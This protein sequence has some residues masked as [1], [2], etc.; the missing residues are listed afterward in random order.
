MTDLVDTAS[1]TRTVCYADGRD[2]DAS[3][4]FYTEV[5]GMDVAMEDPVLG[6]T[7]AA[8]RSAQVLI[9]PAG[10]EEP[11]PRFG[12]DLGHP[13]AVDAAHSAAVRRGLRVVYPLRTEPWGVRRFFVE[14]PGGTIINVLAHTGGAAPSVQPRLVVEDVDAAVAYYER[15]IG[16]ERGSRMAEPSGR[17]VHAELQIGNSTISLTQAYDDSR[18]DSP[19]SPASSPVLLTLTVADA[20]AVGAAMV[21]GGG[22][23]IISIEDRPWGKRQGRIRDPFGHQWVISQDIPPAGE[24]E[25]ETAPGHLP[26]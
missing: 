8:N 9:P 12:I 17:V 22:T 24:R 7:S 5:L 4:A 25:S 11:Q 23:V 20:S 3:R 14:D 16:A 19:Q 1:P 13:Q 2:L 26:N 21:D 15:C 18:V 6:L 10:F